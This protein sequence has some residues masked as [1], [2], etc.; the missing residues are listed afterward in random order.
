MGQPVT[1]AQHRCRSSGVVLAR[2]GII[3]VDR[4]NYC[5]MATGKGMVVAPVAKSLMKLRNQIAH[6]EPDV[7]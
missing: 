7:R 1:R 6:L 3:A 2:R 4:G 5:T